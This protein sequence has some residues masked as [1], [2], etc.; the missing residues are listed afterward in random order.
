MGPMRNTCTLGHMVMKTNMILLRLTENDSKGNAGDNGRDTWERKADSGA[1]ARVCPRFRIG[2]YGAC[3]R[4][5]AGEI[6][7][8]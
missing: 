2:R 6:H 7:R 5:I 4:G 8:V 1:F 3:A